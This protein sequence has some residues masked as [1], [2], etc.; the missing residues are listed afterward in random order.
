LLSFTGAARRYEG[1][2]A[3]ANKAPT[4]CIDCDV[5]AGATKF[6]IEEAELAGRSVS[7]WL[8]VAVVF[9]KLSWADKQRVL[10]SIAAA[11]GAEGRPGAC[12]SVLRASQRSDA[13]SIGES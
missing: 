6:R 2:D 4:G 10:A 5:A 8:Y 3:S 1:C 9:R 11:S 12:P 7:A 13:V